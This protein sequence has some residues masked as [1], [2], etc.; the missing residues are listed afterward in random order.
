MANFRKMSKICKRLKC[1]AGYA[2]IN[3]LS[4]T[5]MYGWVLASK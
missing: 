1:L 2:G 3:R 4:A 5:Q